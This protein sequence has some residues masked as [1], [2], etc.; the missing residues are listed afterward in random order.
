[1]ERGLMIIFYIFDCTILHN[2]V[3]IKN[4]FHQQIT[5]EFDS[6]KTRAFSRGNK[7][8]KYILISTQFGNLKLISRADFPRDNFLLLISFGRKKTEE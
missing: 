3:E 1:M 2:W 8:E 4:T 7:Q 5:N 6:L